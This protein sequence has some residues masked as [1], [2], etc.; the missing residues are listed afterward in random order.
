MHVNKVGSK[1]KNS[2]EDQQ[3]RHTKY[4]KNLIKRLNQIDHLRKQEA[5]GVCLCGAY[6]FVIIGL[7]LC[8]AGDLLTGCLCLRVR[9]CFCVYVSVSVCTCL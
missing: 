8:L 3:V 7:C 6:G 5:D 1:K 9:V 2:V 4:L